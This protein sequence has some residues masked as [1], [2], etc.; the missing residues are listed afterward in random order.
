MRGGLAARCDLDI[1]TSAPVPDTPGTAVHRGLAPNDPRLLALYR[2][3]DIFVLPTHA[4]CLA[5]VLA[6]AM[7]AGLPV[8]TTDVAAQPEAVRDGESG[9]VVPRGDAAAT[10]SAIRR[11]AADPDLRRRMGARGR[12]HA[13]AQFDARRNALRMIDVIEDGIARWR[14]GGH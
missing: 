14:A 5:V 13:A 2:A 7:A 11:L 12:A 1:V 6:E 3:A 8:V 9:I 10:G 4:D